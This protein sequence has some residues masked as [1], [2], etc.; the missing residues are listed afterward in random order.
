MSLRAELRRSQLGSTNTGDL[1]PSCVSCRQSGLREQ[2][3]GRWHLQGGGREGL[4][5]G[6][7][8]DFGDALAASIQNCTRQ[9]HMRQT[10]A[11]NV[12]CMDTHCDPTSARA[13]AGHCQ[14]PG[15][16]VLGWFG[17]TL[18]VSCTAPFTTRY[19]SGSRYLGMS[20][21]NSAAVAGAISDGL[22]THAHPAAIAPACPGNRHCVSRTPTSPSTYE[23]TNAPG[24]RERGRSGS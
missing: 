24:A 14:S 4:R 21:A 13:A 22:T 3:R 17:R 2:G 12:G 5:G 23:Q 6:Q 15:I 9:A 18:V 1:P 7:C 8:N 19:N 16:E 11:P 10:R 20:S